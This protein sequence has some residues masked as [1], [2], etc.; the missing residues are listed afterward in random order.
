MNLQNHSLAKQ[1]QNN[2]VLNLVS[3]WMLCF[4]LLVFA[5]LYG[6]SFER[7]SVNQVGGDV[8]MGLT[9][10]D[11]SQS[12]IVKIQNALC[13]L[14]CVWL[15]FPYSKKVLQWA[16]RELLVIALLG[17]IALSV[18]WSNSPSHS[19][20]G[21]MRMVIDVALALYFVHR[22]TINEQ[23]KIVMLVGSV[24]AFAGLFLVI[25]LPQ[26]GMFIRSYGLAQSWQGIF[27]HKNLSG[28]GMSILI[29]PG[30]FVQFDTRNGE[31]FRKFY[32]GM[33]AV[34]IVM[35]HSASAWVVGFCC[36]LT[37][38]LLN[39]IGRVRRKEAVLLMGTAAGIVVGVLLVAYT[40][41]DVFMKLL[42]K[43]PTM[44]GR[45]VLWADLLI[46]VLKRPLLGYG[47]CAFWQ[48]LDGE[49]ANV[50]IHMGWTGIG[51]A[52]NG[53]YELLLEVGVVGVLLYLL[54]Y[55]RAWKNAVVC[56]RKGL[57]PASKWYI[58]ILAFVLFSNIEAG[59]LMLPSY[60]NCILPFVAY[61][62][63]RDEARRVSSQDS[64]SIVASQSSLDQG[65]KHCD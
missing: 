26:Y 57:T 7:G 17:W 1:M 21:L 15:I 63:L 42:G 35:S 55:L 51:Y 49:S 65:A 48:G 47:F 58:S 24:A 22:Y 44:T 9:A 27:G 4:V 40:N 8:G 62:G 53:V 41:Y 28:L 61:Y 2:S 25:A 64:P 36:I 50:I 38:I 39:V 59:Q 18:L 12:A 13:Y 19:L 5:S 54:I 16:Q 45:T 32:L 52:E 11:L 33:M 20:T 60:L 3:T 31:L 30:F 56:F 6:F 14:I 37:A 29:L 10:T 43:D 46:S 23:F 34:F